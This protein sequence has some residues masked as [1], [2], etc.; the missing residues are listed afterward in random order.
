MQE[1]RTEQTL[2]SLRSLTAPTATVCR[3]GK[4]QTIPARELV[5]GDCIR[6]EAGDNVPADSALVRADGLSVNESILTGE[7]E[8]VSKQSGDPADTR[9]DLHKKNVVYA[10]TAVLHGSAEAVVIA[11]GTRTQMGQI[12]AMLQEVKQDLTPLQKRLA[13]LGKVVALLCLGV[14]GA[15]FLAGVLRGEPVF[16]MLMTG[17]TIAIAAIPEGLPATVTIALALA[18]SRMMKRNALVNRLHSVETLGCASVICS[19]KTGTITE[20]R[21]TVTAVRAGGESFSVTGTGL[22]KA[23]A[24]QQDGRNVNPLSKPAL[25]ELLI[26]GALCCT[27]EIHS[28]QESARR[29]RS[30]RTDK[31][32][33]SAT[34]DPTEVAL[35]VAAEKGG[36]SRQELLRS[37][38]V[39]RSEPFDS[40]TRRMSVTVTQGAGTCTYWKGAADAILPL[41]GFQMRDGKTVPF[42]ESDRAAVRRSVTELSDQALRVLA[43]AR[44][45][46]GACVFLGLAGMLDPPRESARTAIRTCARANIRTVMITGDHKNTAAAIAKQAGLLRGKKGDDR[47]RTG[48]SQRCPAGCL[49]GSVHRLCTGQPGA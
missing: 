43:F 47:R 26:C 15:V 30:A 27:A 40:E 22:Q 2:E 21:M 7:S 11:T 29:D 8:A 18:V 44:Q 10:G 31:G 17:I 13:G 35:L 28:P 34:G 39:L 41:C 5:C 12:S 33:W 25:K 48:R 19:D 14:C 4:W 6:L 38:P 32:S 42:S 46:D 49:P 1:Y 16:D 9:N 20:N 3:D 37:H 45:E 36:V 24:I 23:G